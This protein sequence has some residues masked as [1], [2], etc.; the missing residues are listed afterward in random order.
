MSLTVQVYFHHLLLSSCRIQ[1]EFTLFFF[2]SGYVLDSLVE[3]WSGFTAQ[4]NLAGRPCDAFGYDILNLTI[5]VTHETTS[6]CVSASV[7]VLVLYGANS[8]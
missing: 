1:A 2:F 3:N 7:P 6:R 8:N 5:R 4:L